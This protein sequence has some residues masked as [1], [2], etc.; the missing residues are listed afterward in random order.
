MFGNLRKIWTFSLTDSKIHDRERMKIM[1]DESRTKG[2]VSAL[3]AARRLCEKSGWQLT[4]LQVQKMLY[5]AHMNYVGK[6]SGKPLIDGN[7]EA[8]IYGPVNREVYNKLRVFKSK[9]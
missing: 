8:W 1:T 3:S 6:T 4:N 2:P 9:K 5:L 7:F